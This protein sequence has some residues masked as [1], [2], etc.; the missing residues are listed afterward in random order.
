MLI[1]KCQRQ[2]ESN[3][4]A[5]KP[6]FWRIP[7]SST[8]GIAPLCLPASSSN[9]IRTCGFEVEEFQE[10]DRRSAQGYGERR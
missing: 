8:V 2:R 1:Y 9:R 4:Y 7:L 10:Q 6:P 5:S 3:P